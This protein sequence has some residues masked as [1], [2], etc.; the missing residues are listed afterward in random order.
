MVRE[1][2]EQSSASIKRLRIGSCC[3]GYG[4]R[5][6]I[7]DFPLKQ[8]TALEILDIDT[9]QLLGNNGHASALV[10]T[11]PESIKMVRI[12]EIPD[13]DE[14]DNLFRSFARLRGTNL[15]NLEKVI[16]SS[17]SEPALQQFQHAVE[18]AGINWTIIEMKNDWH[19]FQD[20]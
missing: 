20:S 3:D 9:V 17:E 7:R 1:L 4:S 14:V 15:P 6:S 2:V 16:V 13:V 10:D 5:R 18:M 12:K 19:P 8:L 11:M